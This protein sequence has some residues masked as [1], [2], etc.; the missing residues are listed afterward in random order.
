MLEADLRAPLIC[1]RP[2]ISSLVS[3]PVSAGPHPVRQQARS[4]LAFLCSTTLARLV[5]QLAFSPSASRSHPSAITCR[6]FLCDRP[7]DL[8]HL[9]SGRFL[10][11]EQ[12]GLA[13]WLVGPECRRR[14]VRLSTRVR[15]LRLQVGLRR[16]RTHGPALYINNHRSPDAAVE[17]ASRLL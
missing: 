8:L 5:P 7:W 11:P 2:G 17:R 4:G 13:G 9:S 14:W 1:R 10:F 15:G 16:I 3:R 12:Q 6:V